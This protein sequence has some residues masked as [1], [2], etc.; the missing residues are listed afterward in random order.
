[1]IVLAAERLIWISS[2]VQLTRLLIVQYLDS[3]ASRRGEKYEVRVQYTVMYKA[4]VR[5]NGGPFHL[6]GQNMN[7]R[8]ASQ[9]LHAQRA[10]EADPRATVDAIPIALFLPHVA[11]ITASPNRTS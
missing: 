8:E 4:V 3:I 9:G 1:M 11:G 7:G 10:H 6:E 2:Y 5:Q